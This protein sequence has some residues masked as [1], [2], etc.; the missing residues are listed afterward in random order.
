MAG[1]AIA[2]SSAGRQWI[3]FAASAPRNVGEGAYAF[4][5][6]RS[7]DPREPRGDIRVRRIQRLADLVAEIEPAIEQD[8]GQRES[9]AA[10]IFPAVRH[11]AVEPL[12]AVGRDL[13]QP[14]RGFRRTGNPLLEKLQRLAE[15]IAVGE[16]LG[17]C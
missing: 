16:R 13:L 2:S 17:R 1:E 15:A 9:L 5:D 3:C 4:T 11:L 6:G 10:E 7:P 14:G 8:V 12:Q